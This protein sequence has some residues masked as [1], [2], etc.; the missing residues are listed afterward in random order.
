MGS[1]VIQI[2][3]APYTDPFSLFSP[4]PCTNPPHICCSWGSRT[5]PILK[6]YQYEP[7]GEEKKIISESFIIIDQTCNFALNVR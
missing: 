6:L 5:R 4:E 3:V 1:Q 2:N 7:F